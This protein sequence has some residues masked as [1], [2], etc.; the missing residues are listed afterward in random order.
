MEFRKTQ[1]RSIGIFNL[2][3][4][5]SG[6]CILQTS[7]WA[8]RNIQGAMLH[9]NGC[10]EKSAQMN[11]AWSHAQ[12]M[13]SEV[14]ASCLLPTSGS[15]VSEF[16]LKVQGAQ[17]SSYCGKARCNRRH[18][19][20]AISVSEAIFRHRLWSRRWHWKALP[21]RNDH[22]KQYGKLSTSDSGHNM[23]QWI[24]IR[25]MSRWWTLFFIS[26]WGLAGCPVNGNL[27]NHELT[28]SGLYPV[29]PMT[30]GWWTCGML[31][32][33]FAWL[34]RTHTHIKFVQNTSVRV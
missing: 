16:T 29:G 8:C 34:T 32:R 13:H 10:T 23:S 27:T 17:G 14:P 28:K 21:H 20:E 9:Q 11:T 24:L 5:I 31:L 30:L 15:S 3:Q 25:F 33:I 26:P 6:C 4:V 12:F 19:S 7:Y 1:I 22:S 2:G 18:A